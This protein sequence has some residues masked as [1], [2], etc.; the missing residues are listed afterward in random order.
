MHSAH[1]IT[2]RKYSELR[3]LPSELGNSSNIGKYLTYIRTV[4]LLGYFFAE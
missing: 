4:L 2:A 1:L 3:P